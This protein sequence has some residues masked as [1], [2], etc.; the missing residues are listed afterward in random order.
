MPSPMIPTLLLML[1]YSSGRLILID[2]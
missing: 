1:A 2:E